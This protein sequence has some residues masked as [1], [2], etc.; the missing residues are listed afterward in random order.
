MVSASLGSRLRAVPVPQ[1]IAELPLVDFGGPED[2]QGQGALAGSFGCA[3]ANCSSAE[4]VRGL[5]VFR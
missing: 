4:R 3:F 2:Q 5:G 1:S